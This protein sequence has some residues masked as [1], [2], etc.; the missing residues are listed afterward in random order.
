MTYVDQVLNDVRVQLA[1][2]DLAL[3][4]A[5]ERR[6]LTRK[7]AE[8]FR[9]A[10]RSYRSG[11][12][13]Y[14]TANCPVHERDKGFDADCGVVLDRR[15]HSLLGPD[16]LDIGPT[17]VVQRVVAHILPTIRRR[18]PSA[19]AR[20]TKRA[21]LVEFHE[22]LA[23]S[24][25]PTVDLI[26]A[27]NR[28]DEPGL[29]IPNT[30]VDRWD[31][32]DP[33]KH[34][35]LFTSGDRGLRVARAQSV[36]LAKAENR[37]VSAPPLCSF[38]LQSL[39]WMFVEPGM[40]TPEALAALWSKGAADLRARLTPDPAGVSPPI[41]VGDRDD[42]V[43]RL[44]FA[45]QRLSAA[46]AH[47]WDAE[48]VRAQLSPLWPDFISD[49]GGVSKARLAAAIKNQSYLG[50]TA[51]GALTTTASIGSALKHTRAYGD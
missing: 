49:D 45:A 19:S 6:D 26:V 5:R 42:A 31:A 48:W 28:K 32:S 40:S 51:A 35:E 38:N 37:R 1:P 30:E 10:L 22:P 50:V 29:W 33:E 25:D 4:E 12:L 8:S 14:G 13:A 3:D 47:P 41:K 34:T 18:Y 2:D 9:G 46:L 15:V 39:A 43:R 27:L 20:V 44:E 11:S 23:T 36:R 17:E 24:D 21:I 7:A 16:G